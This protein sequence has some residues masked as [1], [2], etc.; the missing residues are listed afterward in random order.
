M[1]GSKSAMFFVPLMVLR[2]SGDSGAL[3]ANN[4]RMTKQQ[5]SNNILQITC[6]FIVLSISQANYSIVFKPTYKSEQIK[7]FSLLR[8][9]FAKDQFEFRGERTRSS[10]RGFHLLKDKTP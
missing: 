4:G 5:V 3:K 1:P 9:V 7:T 10:N 6:D 8:L 2:V